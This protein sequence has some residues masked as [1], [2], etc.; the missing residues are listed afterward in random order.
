MVESMSSKTPVKRTVVL[1]SVPGASAGLWSHLLSELEGHGYN[2]EDIFSIH[3][4][5]EE[6]FI[7]AVS[8]GSNFEPDKTVKVEYVVDMDKVK[9]DLTDAG[10]GFDPNMVPDPRTEENRYKTSGRGLFLMQ[11]YMDTVEFNE[12]GNCVHMVRFKRKTG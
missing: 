1:S 10:D 5:F 2:R 7:N 9:L 8:H 12:Q 11:S 3:I 6:A 4:A